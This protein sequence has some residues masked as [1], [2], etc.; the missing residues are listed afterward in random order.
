M[1]KSLTTPTTCHCALPSTSFII[2]PNRIFYMHKFYRRFIEHYGIAIGWIII[3]INISALRIIFT[4]IVLAKSAS[5]PRR[6]KS[7]FSSSLVLPSHE[8]P[9]LSLHLFVMGFAHLVME[10]AAPLLSKSCFIKS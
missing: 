9:Q 8:Y 7:I 10:T 4:P 5:A 6:T 1:I 2:K 3:Y